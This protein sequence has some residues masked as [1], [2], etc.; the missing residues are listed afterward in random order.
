MKK[1][2]GQGWVDHVLPEN[3]GDWRG[4]AR[5]TKQR[6]TRRMQLRIQSRM[7]GTWGPGAPYCL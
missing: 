2:T 7:V 5:Q 6:Q 3:D 4:E 1:I